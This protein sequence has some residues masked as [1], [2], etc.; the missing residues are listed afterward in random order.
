MSSNFN[1]SA[2]SLAKMMLLELSISILVIVGLF[3]VG[4][5]LTKRKGK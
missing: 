3:T 2:W 5:W 4:V 1:R